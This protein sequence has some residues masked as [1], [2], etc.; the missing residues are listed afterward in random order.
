M[1]Y[2]FFVFNLLCFSITINAQVESFAT[3]TD[4]ETAKQEA[5]ASNKNIL[6]VFAGSD[7]CKPCMQFKKEILDASAFQQWAK[8]ELVVLY[9]D[10][11]AR[12]KN[13]LP[14][15]ETAHNEALAERFNKSGAFPNVIL[16]DTNEQIIANPQFKNQP[17]AE[18]ISALGKAKPK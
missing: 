13:K 15:T 18:F 11:P 2:L 6:M 3:F 10:F 8:E 1:K 17:V 12:K 4:L 16:I 7:W 9:L 5:V 14:K